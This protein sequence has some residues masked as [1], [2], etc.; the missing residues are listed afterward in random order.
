MTIDCYQRAFVIDDSAGD[1]AWMV[2][3][4]KLLYLL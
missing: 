3:D 2:R 4:D 1:G